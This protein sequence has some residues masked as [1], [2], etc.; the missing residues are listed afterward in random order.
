MAV[1]GRMERDTVVGSVHVFGRAVQEIKG[2]ITS[3][4]GQP[5]R[6]VRFIEFRCQH[7]HADPS[8]REVGQRGI[9][10]QLVLLIHLSMVPIAFMAFPSQTAIDR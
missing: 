8:R 2:R 5:R 1:T 7:D 9:Q 4:G 10:V 6:F 3:G